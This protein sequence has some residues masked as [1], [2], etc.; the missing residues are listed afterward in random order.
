MR[1]ASGENPSPRF[2]SSV[3]RKASIGFFRVLLGTAGLESGLKAQSRGGSPAQPRAAVRKNSK[4]TAR[5]MAN[6]RGGNEAGTTSSLQADWVVSNA[7]RRSRA[8]QWLGNGERRERIR[9]GV[10]QHK[11]TQIC[12]C[13]REIAPHKSLSP[14]SIQMFPSHA[15]QHVRGCDQATEMP[16]Y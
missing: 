4:R 9:V 10:M 6:H 16:A 7:N 15:K 14:I 1:S 11:T 3:S 8:A 13:A 2:S 5:R 12:P